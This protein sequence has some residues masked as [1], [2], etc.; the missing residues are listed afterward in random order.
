MNDPEAKAIVDEIAAI[1]DEPLFDG[2]SIGVVTLLGTAQA[3]RIHEMVSERISPIDV[4][5]RKI[6]IGP[7]ARK[8]RATRL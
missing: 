4:V 3:A 2:R 7:L 1:L 8:L 5:A 6:A